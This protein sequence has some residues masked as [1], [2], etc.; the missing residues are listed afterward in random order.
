MTLNPWRLRLLDVFDRVGTVRGV[1]AELRLSPSTVSQQLAVLESE[2]G[3]QVF[4]RAGRSLRL[5]PT[6]R[7][8][9]ERA[10]DLR[11]HM[12]SIEAELRDA[13]TGVAGH[14]RVAG[15]ASSIEPILIPAIH[16]LQAQH[17][18]LLIEIQEIEPRASTTA[19]HQGLCDIVITVDEE[20]GSL[21]APGIAVVPL[22]TDPMQ[23]VVPQ[24]HRVASWDEV[25][26]AELAPDRW[27]LD[28]PG[29]YLGE[30][31]P[32]HCRAE[33]FEPVVAGRFS[34][35]AVVLAHVAAGFSVAVL[36]ELAAP[37]RPGL[38]RRPVV[39]LADRRIVAAVRRAGTARPVVA[40]VLEAL[41]HVS[42]SRAADHGRTELS[43]HRIR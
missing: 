1:A 8:L 32:R 29:T 4:E 24:T 18:R 27:A 41:R 12:D 9:V 39:G 17:P 37:L 43:A 14:L 19:L 2:T 25:R 3:A 40:A 20:D 16:E 6:G 21:L 5:T 35:Y 26:L 30:L 36:P 10:R 38:V 23:V 15:F 7:M 13:T 33:G 11:D 31:V 22:A 42:G 34:S 28:L